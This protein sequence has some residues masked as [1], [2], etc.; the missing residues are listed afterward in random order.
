MSKEEAVIFLK[1]NGYNAELES[2]VVTVTLSKDEYE[3]H[4]KYE[5][6]IKKLLSENGYHSSWG[7]RY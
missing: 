1:E 7:V 5:K 6:K 3:K 4:A 2:G